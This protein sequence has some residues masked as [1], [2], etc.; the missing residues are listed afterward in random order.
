ME[1]LSEERQDRIFFRGVFMLIAALVCLMVN[2]FIPVPS[3]VKVLAGFFALIGIG[4]ALHADSLKTMRLSYKSLR[5]L[6]GPYG[7]LVI[8][9]RGWRNWIIHITGAHVHKDVPLGEEK[10]SHAF[11][12]VIAEGKS[13]QGAAENMEQIFSSFSVQKGDVCERGCPHYLEF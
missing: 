6:G 12:S 8:R 3:S 11:S 10:L 1:I 9:K 13:F 4:F 7:E 5:D 2:V